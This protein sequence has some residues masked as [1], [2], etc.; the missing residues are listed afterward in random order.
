MDNARVYLAQADSLNWNS[1][2]EHVHESNMPTN[3][4]FLPSTISCNSLLNVKDVDIG[5][6]NVKLFS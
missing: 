5:G 6:M 2:S 1:L 4:S 3:P